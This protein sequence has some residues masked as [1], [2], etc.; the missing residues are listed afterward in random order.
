MKK[1]IAASILALVAADGG[2]TVAKAEP[3]P[4]GNNNHGLCT[5]YFSGSENG[6]AHKR[7][8]PPFQALEEAA[9][10]EEDDTQ[11]QRDAAVRE[12]CQQTDPKFNR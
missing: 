8:A 2:V 3:G 7:N 12:Y 1:L 9:G 11:E 5:A 10:V 4:N 6:R